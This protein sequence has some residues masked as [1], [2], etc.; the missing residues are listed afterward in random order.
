MLFDEKISDSNLITQIPSYLKKGDILFC[1]VKQEIND[2]LYNIG[3]PSIGN[4]GFSNDHCAMYIGKNYFVESFPYRIRPLRMNVFGV[5][6]SPLWKIKLWAS[7]ITYAYVNTDQ[8]TRNEAVKWALMRLG[9]PYQFFWSS[10]LNPNPNDPNDVFS[11][12]WICSELIWA[13]YWNNNL[14][15]VI[16]SEYSD[17]AF[18]VSTPGQLRKADNVVLYDN[19]PPKAVTSGSYSGY[20]NET[21]HF[22]G[23]DS[24]DNDGRITEYKWDFGD[25]SEDVG[26]YVDHIYTKPGIKKI[27]LT[28]TDNGGLH[29]SN[30]TI[31][32][33]KKLNFPPLDPIIE[34]PSSAFVNELCNFTIFSSDPDNDE[35]KYIID[36]DDFSINSSNYALKKIYNISHQWNSSGFYSIN[37]E[38]CDYNLS[39]YSYKSIQIMDEFIPDEKPNYYVL[40]LV[41]VIALVIFFIIY[42]KNKKNY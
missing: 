17:H 32:T 20:T 40:F 34:G 33:I 6:I 23:D 7:N 5:T 19:K 31:V 8:Q 22:S 9:S 24:Y 18:N 30:E 28:V 10:E 36:W 21:I 3:L 16:S 35:I 29:D 2:L 27:I 39:S 41:L 42:L 26:R 37:V 25:G 14:K 15:L 11:N 38:V 12:R 4:R 13:A 1:D